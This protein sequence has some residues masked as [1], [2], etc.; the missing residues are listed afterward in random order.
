MKRQFKEFNFRGKALETI[1]K[2]NEIIDEYVRKG[3]DLTLRQLYYQFVARGYIENSQKSYN[4]LGVIINNARLNGDLDWDAIKDRTR[5]ISGDFHWGSP[6]RII[7]NCE[8]SFDLDTRAT[9][10]TYIEVWVEKEALIGVVEKAASALDIPYF[11]CRGYVSQTAM[12]DAY[13]RINYEN[14]R[15]RDSVIIHLGDHDPSGIDMSRDIKERINDTFG[16][17]LK[18]E[19]IALNMDQIEQYA[20]PP[21][22]AKITDSRCDGYI[23]RYG[24][25]SWELDALEPSVIVDLI[26]ATA[27]NYT[28][29]AKQD[30]L[31]AQQQEHRDLLAK[32]SDNWDDVVDYLGRLD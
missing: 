2:A 13:K 11:A 4:N 18:L 1:N 9:Q 20:P 17:S 6:A 19:R 8:Y 15:G 28:D 5:D 32:C 25:L 21:N 16:A 10:D 23:K 14:Q 12:Y 3:Y 22:P 30:A 26:K 27:L 24:K 31:I 7:K 29:V